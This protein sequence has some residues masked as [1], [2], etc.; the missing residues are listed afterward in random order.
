MLTEEALIFLGGLAALG[1]VALGVLELLWP[2]RPKHPARP[3]SV[4]P[5]PPPPLPPL[6]VATSLAPP[7][8]WRSTRRRHALNGPRTPYRRREPGEPA[9]VALRAAFEEEPL[10]AESNAAVSESEVDAVEQCFALYQAGEYAAAIAAATAG[11]A[12]K[13]ASGEATMTAG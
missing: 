2:A 12:V 7:R 10:P 11:M 5:T 1:A 4:T 8:R 3:A 13:A 6:P 9:S